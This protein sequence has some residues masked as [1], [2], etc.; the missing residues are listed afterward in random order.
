MEWFHF[1]FGSEK[2]GTHA[3]TRVAGTHVATPALPRGHATNGIG[4]S[5]MHNLD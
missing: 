4:G 2:F 3:T 5:P 1:L